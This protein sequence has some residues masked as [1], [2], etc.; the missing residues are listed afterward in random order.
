[1][2]ENE[3]QPPERRLDPSEFILDKEHADYLQA[4]GL[5]MQ[6]VRELRKTTTQGSCGGCQ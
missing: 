3:R 4:Q 6:E 5:E 1:M 2:E